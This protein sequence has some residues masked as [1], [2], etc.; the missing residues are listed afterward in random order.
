MHERAR[1]LLLEVVCSGAAH[2][3][4]A[5]EV[6]LDDLIEVHDRHAV[7]NAVAQDARIVDHAIDALEV[8][9]RALDDLFRALRLGDALEVR[10][11][12]AAGLADFLDDL[13]GGLLARGALAVHRGA[14]VIDDDLRALMGGQDGH[15]P[16]DAAACAGHYYDFAF[17]AASHRRCL[18]SWYVSGLVCG[19]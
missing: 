15:A 6:H 11:G 17:Q 8:V 3:E 5:V 4:G 7:E 2:I 13:F 9:E 1:L 19:F 14:E 18:S 12:L 10:D 16:A